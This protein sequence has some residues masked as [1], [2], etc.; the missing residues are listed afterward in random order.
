MGFLTSH[1]SAHVQRGSG[2]NTDTT[3]THLNSHFQQ[4]LKT[5]KEWLPLQYKLAEFGVGENKT[6]WWLCSV[7]ATSGSKEVS[8]PG[9]MLNSSPHT[10]SH[11][12]HELASFPYYFPHTYLWE[13]SIPHR[14]ILT[15]QTCTLLS[16]KKDNS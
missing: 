12:T 14:N 11:S 16:C 8:G 15:V 3:L 1:S 6:T 4:L 10:Y 2:A 7:V 5:A 9:R 13:R